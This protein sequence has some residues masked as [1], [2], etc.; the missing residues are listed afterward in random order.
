MGHLSPQPEDTPDI[1]AAKAAL[2][3]DARVISPDLVRL[4]EAVLRDRGLWI[5]KCAEV[6]DVM[7]DS[8]Y[9]LQGHTE[10][11][12]KSLMH[13]H[14]LITEISAMINPEDS[15]PEQPKDYVVKPDLEMLEGRN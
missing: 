5:A 10:V 7:L 13:Q 12:R 6:R 15:E 2:N 4:L 9:V 14:K 11:Q 1:L 3:S 8:V